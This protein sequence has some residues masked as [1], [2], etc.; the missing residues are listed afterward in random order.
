[1][2]KILS[3]KIYMILFGCFV[4]NFGIHA[5]IKLSIVARLNFEVDKIYSSYQDSI[6][7]VKNNTLYEISGKNCVEVFISNN[8]ITGI[9]FNSSKLVIFNIN[10]IFVFDVVSKQLLWEKKIKGRIMAE[11]TLTSDKLF[12]DKDARILTALDI[13]TGKYVWRTSIYSE[14][15]QFFT[16]AKFLY[17]N[18]YI[19]YIYS[20]RKISVLSKNS[21]LPK[22]SYNIQS[23]DPLAC[24]DHLSITT[25]KIY[26][27]ILYVMYNNGDFFAF[28]IKIGECIFG[29]SNE[30]Y[31][32]FFLNF[33]T[34]VI[35]KKPADII[36][37]NK[38]TG[39]KILNTTV[40]EDH[41]Y[42]PI[43]L[44]KK[45][46][47]LVYN[48]NNVKFLD[49]KDGTSVYVNNFKK[50]SIKKIIV[51]K[52]EKKLWIV[53]CDNKIVFVELN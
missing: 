14:D 23:F 44:S 52:S 51:S 8:G 24:N 9:V 12:I 43:I 11:P 36:F 10:E 45:K 4:I 38:F 2:K 30:Q 53:T 40:F 16:N 21:G 41:F 29:D 3:V 19:I 49:I 47:I 17:T 31:V 7:V 18:D 20:N 32:D 33:D 5:N 42:I 28:D 34:V 26:N 50:M 48:N 22:K 1:M 13:N 27:D 25:A 6:Y 15:E 37:Y 35:F 46:L 39:K